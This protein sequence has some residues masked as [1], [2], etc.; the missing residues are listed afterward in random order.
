MYDQITD[1]SDYLDSFLAICGRDIPY[2][3]RQG[4]EA[5][6]RLF[7]TETVGS[8]HLPETS[9]I[10]GKIAGTRVEF[11]KTYRGAAEVT[12]TVREQEVSSFRREG[13]KVQYLGHLDLE[14]MC[15]AGRWVI[16][17]RGFLGWILPP[18]S[19]GRFEL[20]KKS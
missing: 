10:Q 15:I 18:Q 19:W 16:R 20:Y 6:I 9:D 5:M 12:W 11:T 13:H 7:G 2:E 1:Q 4:F 3:A 8:S 14:P 17:S